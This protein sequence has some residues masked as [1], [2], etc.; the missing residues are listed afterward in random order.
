MAPQKKAYSTLLFLFRQDME[1][2]D[3]D[4]ALHNIPYHA[5]GQNERVAGSVSC[6]S[7]TQ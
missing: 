2:W 4:R 3:E 6:L 1:Q 5:G 7:K